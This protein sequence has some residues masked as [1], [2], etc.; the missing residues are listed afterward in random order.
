MTA[1]SLVAHG[2]AY[3]LVAPDP[4]ARVDLLARTG[5][6]YL[7]AAPF[8]LGACLAFLLAGLA[9]HAS[10]GFLRRAPARAPAW[11]LALLPL[12]GF[13][14]QEHL[15]RLAATG[16]LPFSAATEPTFLVGLALQLP[17]ALVALVAARVLGRAAEVVGRA[18]APALPRPALRPRTATRP[19]VAL[20]PN[21]PRLAAAQSGRAPPR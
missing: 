8:V 17:F 5:H 20:L 1:G 10:R 7:E 14:C 15:E 19:V 21:A 18:L 13:A 16:D 4:D 12:L 11:P 2:L 3:R 9:A 6:G